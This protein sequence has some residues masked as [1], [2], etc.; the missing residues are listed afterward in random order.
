MEAGKCV[1]APLGALI[2][3]VLILGM[4]IA[5]TP[6]EAKSCC[7]STVGRNCYNVYRLRFARPVCASTC[8]CKI[9]KGNRCPSSY[10]K[11]SGFL[12]SEEFEEQTNVEDQAYAF[13]EYCKLGCVLHGH[14][15]VNFRMYCISVQRVNYGF[16]QLTFCKCATCFRYSDSEHDNKNSNYSSW[17]DG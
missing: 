6:V 14:I 2:M 12:N 7:K 8:S 10:P 17:T 1:K 4:F 11:I 13:N 9:D 15:V 3:G 5:Q 16:I